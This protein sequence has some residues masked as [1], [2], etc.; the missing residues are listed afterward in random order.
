MAEENGF[1]VGFNGVSHAGIKGSSAVVLVIPAE[2]V[3]VAIRSTLVCFLIDLHQHVEVR[4]NFFVIIEFVR[5]FPSV[6]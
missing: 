6:G 1:G 5:A 3:I 2:G 4:L